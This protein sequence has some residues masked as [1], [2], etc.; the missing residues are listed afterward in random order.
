MSSSAPLRASSLSRIAIERLSSPSLKLERDPFDPWG[1]YRW[2]W[3]ETPFC[4]CFRFPLFAVQE[5]P[6]RRILSLVLSAIWRRNRILHLSRGSRERVLVDKRGR[7]G[8]EHAPQPKSMYCIAFTQLFAPL[9]TPPCSQ[10]YVDCAKTI[11]MI[12]L[13]ARVS[14]VHAPASQEHLIAAPAAAAAS[15]QPSAPEWSDFCE[16]TRVLRVRLSPLWGPGARRT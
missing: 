6:T 10:F 4:F 1:L 14:G 5:G 16:G 8:L 2:R 11:W 3:T 13:R 7:P 9:S 15:K 12:L